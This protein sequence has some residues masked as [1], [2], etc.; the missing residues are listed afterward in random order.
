MHRSQ[1]VKGLFKR[2]VEEAKAV[3]NDFTE[4]LQPIGLLEYKEAF[5]NSGLTL[6]VRR[7]RMFL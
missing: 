7:S 3:P 6:E 1:G 4:L 2:Q 5:E